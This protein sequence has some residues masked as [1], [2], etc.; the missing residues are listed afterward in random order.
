VAIKAIAVSVLDE[1]KDSEI[2]KPCGSCRQVIAEYE[3][4]SGKPI[5]IIL[6][7]GN[8]ISICEGI[9]NLLPLHF[10]KKDLK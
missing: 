3:D 2:A 7:G 9:D 8:K 10:K 1:E 6:D 4:L 5:R